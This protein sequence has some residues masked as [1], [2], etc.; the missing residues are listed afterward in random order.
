MSHC[1]QKGISEQQVFITLHV[2]VDTPGFISFSTRMSFEKVKKMSKDHLFLKTTF[3]ITDILVLMI[4]L[5]SDN[6][7]IFVEFVTLLLLLSCKLQFTRLNDHIYIRV[8]NKSPQS[9]LH[10]PAVIV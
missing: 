1:S 8:R 5:L 10:Y 3:Y 9:P 6:Q 2:P 7:F 4:E